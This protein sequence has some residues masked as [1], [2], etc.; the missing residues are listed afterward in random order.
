MVHRTWFSG[1]NRIVIFE[2]SIIYKAFNLGQLISLC[3]LLLVLC[4]LFFAPQNVIQVTEL[5]SLST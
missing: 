4:S 5:N 3:S 2:W 1:V